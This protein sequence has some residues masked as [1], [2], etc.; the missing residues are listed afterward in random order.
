MCLNILHEREPKQ[1]GM[2][3][4]IDGNQKEER[5]QRLIAL[6][7]QKEED[8]HKSYLGKEVEILWEEEKNGYYQGHTQNYLLAWCKSTQYLEN[9]I[10]KAKCV[11]AKAD[12]LLVEVAQ[13]NKTVTNT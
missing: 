7:S 9:K 8:Y 6:S 4:Q 10:T 1:L 2:V 11:E 3:G 12:H 13:C 5:S